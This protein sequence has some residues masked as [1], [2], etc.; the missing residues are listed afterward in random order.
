MRDSYTSRARYVHGKRRRAWVLRA[1]PGG[2]PL[3]MDPGRKNE[4]SESQSSV[5]AI[6]RAKLLR[7]RFRRLFTVPRLHPV[8]SAISS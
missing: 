1:P 2:V 8:I 3:E 5:G 7:A 6:T 4:V